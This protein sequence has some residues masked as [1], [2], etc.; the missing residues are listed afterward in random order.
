MPA[1]PPVEESYPV[2]KEQFEVV[3]LRNSVSDA[4]ALPGDFKRIEVT[5]TDP[6]AAQM[7][8]LVR[9]ETGYTVLFAAK[10]GVMT[11]PEIHARRRE[12]DAG[13]PDRRNI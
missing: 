10:P 5:A 3:M 9:A 2:H 7:S 4:H 6:L 12:M 11:D 1:T 8:D 13:Q